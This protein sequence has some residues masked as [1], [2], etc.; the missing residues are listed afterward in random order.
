VA[1]EFIAC[2][3]KNHGV[4]ILSE[5][6]GAGQAIGS[7]A[8]LVNPFNTDALAKAIYDSLHMPEEERIERH[9]FM[10]EYV[11][12]YTIQNW[13]ENFVTELQT[14]E[15]D[16]ELLSLNVPTPLPTASVIEAYKSAGRRLIILGL[17]DTL[18]D[19]EAFKSMEPIDD[20][21][22][23]DLAI[24][25]SDP[26]NTVVVIT[27]RERALVGQ[28]LGDLP[29]W[30]AAENGVYYRMS[31]TR[32]AEWQSEYAENLDDQWIGSIRPVFRYFEERTPGSVTETQEHS[33]TWHYREAD[34]DFGEIQASVLQEHL[35]K[36]LGNQPVEVSLDMKQVQVRPYAVS[37]GA[38]LDVLM[39]ATTEYSRASKGG[40]EKPLGEE[41]D[42]NT[43]VSALAAG[44]SGDNGGSLGVVGTHIG[45]DD[46]LG[47]G[48]HPLGGMRSSEPSEGGAT[49][50]GLRDPLDM[51]VCVGCHSMRDE[52]IFGNLLS[53]DDDDVPYAD[54]LPEQTWTCRVGEQPSQAKHFVDDVRAV[55]LLLSSLAS[56]SHT[57]PPPEA[58]VHG[59]IIGDDATGEGVAQTDLVASA[60]DHLE[61]IHQKIG[62]RQLA[63]FLDYDG[64]LTPIVENPSAAILSE[65]ARSVVRAL[66]ARYPTAIV[67]GRARATAQGLVQLDELY[68]A[69]SHGFD[70]AGPLRPTGRR[71]SN[72]DPTDSGRLEEVSEKAPSISYQVADSFRPALEEAKAQVE[73]AIRD[74]KGAMVEDNTFSVSVHYRMVAEGEDRELVLDIVNRVVDNMPMLR[75]TEGKMVYELRPSADWDKGKAVEW[76]LEQIQKE[77]EEDVFPVYIG[78]DVTDEDAFRMMGDL[79]GLGI[80]V[81][82]TAVEDGTAATYALHNPAHVVQF[83]DYFAKLG[84]DD[85]SSRISVVSG[86][87]S[88]LASNLPSVP[89]V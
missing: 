64:T 69:G 29:V 53:K 63:F 39:D 62:Q 11:S 45:D 80:I 82:E 28:W 77:M 85:D 60:L 26:R 36:V 43:A 23:K 73:E 72:T 38:F 40:E 49:L 4:L 27:G 54:Y 24:L 32:S 30:I 58:S 66:A 17:L 20:E 76:L 74:I 56:L 44:G 9:N 87:Q 86:S 57:L 46:G 83:L 41:R 16:H 35:E 81:S 8:I 12:K 7:G 88:N 89:E 5:F 68:Y 55:Q 21:A 78:D 37:K 18:I 34:E 6:I 33:I 52:D 51:I 1:F 65:E 42:S 22:W 61:G 10:A 70:I 31:G 13:A 3:Q 47:L 84:R 2:Q 25:A 71:R 59:S 15:Q 75:R 50:P 19:F 79:G 14:Q 67:S 48:T